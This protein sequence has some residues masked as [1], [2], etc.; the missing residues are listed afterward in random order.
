MT[1][2]TAPP[3]VVPQRASDPTTPLRS[4]YW[5]AVEFTGLVIYQ[6]FHQME[7]TLAVANQ[8]LGARHVHPVLGG[9][10]FEWLHLGFNA[11]LM[12]GFVVVLIG[13]GAPGRA[14]W[15]ALHRTYWRIFVLGVAVQGYH[16]VEHVVRTMQYVASGGE[17]PG[18]ATRVLDPA[19][20]HFGINLA[21]LLAMV[22]AFFGLRIPSDLRR[23][24]R[25]VH[26]SADQA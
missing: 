9:I 8:K 26:A 24:P 5:S 21:V 11:M 19:W 1:T 10:D 15:R 14:A 22:T 17:P 18:I 23:K 6:T 13:Y 2:T 4:R 25:R 20:F 3:P 7:H 16:L 12:W